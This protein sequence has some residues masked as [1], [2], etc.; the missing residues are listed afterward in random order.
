MGFSRAWL[1]PPLGTGQQPG[2]L[3][4]MGLS[5]AKAPSYMWLTSN[6]IRQHLK[7][8]PWSPQARSL[9]G[10]GYSTQR[11]RASWREVTWHCEALGVCQVWGSPLGSILFLESS[12]FP[13]LE[14]SHDHNAKLRAAS[15]EGSLMSLPDKE[16][17]LYV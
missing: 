14:L 13:G 10:K 7:F 1:P 17:P 8:R 3:L 12:S 6:H 4:E 5:N 2:L 16:V 11:P 9:C 15:R